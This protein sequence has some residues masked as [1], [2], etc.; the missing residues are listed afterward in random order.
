L[1]NVVKKII[2][3]EKN[4]QQVID[5]AEKEKQDKQVELERRLG[6]LK[7]EIAEGAKRKVK[8]IRQEELNGATKEAEDIIAKCSTQ[9]EVMEENYEKNKERWKKELVEAVLMR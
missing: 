9:I 3:I 5:D 8:E 2:D 7:K 6:I 1:E 4:A